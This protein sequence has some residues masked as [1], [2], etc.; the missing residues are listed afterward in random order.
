MDI[1]EVMLTIKQQSISQSDVFK[2]DIDFRWC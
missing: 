2:L 1:A